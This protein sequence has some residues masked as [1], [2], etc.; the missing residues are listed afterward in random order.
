MFW[1]QPLFTASSLSPE[2]SVHSDSSLIQT[3]FLILH[4]GLFLNFP[5]AIL[6]FREEYLS[7][8]LVSWGGIFPKKILGFSLFLLLGRFEN[9]NWICPLSLALLSLGIFLPA[10]SL[11]SPKSSRALSLRVY[12]VGW[13][14]KAYC[15]ILPNSGE[16][17]IPLGQQ[18][19][20]HVC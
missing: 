16:S 6:I 4:L 9:N 12:V 7:L 17:I 2:L 5:L 3:I 11:T 8:L 13:G 20:I 18:S 19:K 15:G 14:M 10:G 1:T